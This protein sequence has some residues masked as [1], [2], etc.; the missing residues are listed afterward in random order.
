MIK[1]KDLLNEIYSLKPQDLVSVK[2]M[3]GV[4]GFKSKIKTGIDKNSKLDDNMKLYLKD[5]IDG[6]VN[7]KKYPIEN[8]TFFNEVEKD[9][10]EVLGAIYVANGGSIEFPTSLTFPLVDFLVHDKNKIRQYSAKGGKSTSNTMKIKDIANIIDNNTEYHS[11]YKNTFIYYVMNILN[12]SSVK[13]AALNLADVLNISYDKNKQ[14]DGHERY[15]VEREVINY[16]NKEID[17]FNKMINSILTIDYV[18]TKIDSKTGNSTITIKSAK[19]IGIKFRS[20]N[21]APTAHKPQ[22][23]WKD[24]IGFQVK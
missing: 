14:D 21:N 1:L 11:L 20:K 15:R 6:K 17:K 9:F 13:D 23:R 4:S 5:L 10:G 22:G 18:M 24:K 19:N 12:Q 2:N 8:K 7:M 3:Y 16:L